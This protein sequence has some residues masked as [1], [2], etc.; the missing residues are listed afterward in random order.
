MEPEAQEVEQAPLSEVVSRLDAELGGSEGPEEELFGEAPEAF[1]A[2][3]RSFASLFGSEDEEEAAEVDPS[4]MLVNCGLSETTVG[5][6]EQRG[7]TALFPIQKVVFEP[8]MRGTDLIAR[9]KTGSG[10]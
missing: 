3:P 10:E 7:I 6:L 4:L 9:A 8:A 2:T 5:A 1:G